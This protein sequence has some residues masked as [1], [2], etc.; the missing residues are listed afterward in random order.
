M[1]DDILIPEERAFKEKLLEM[2]RE[3]I[4]NITKA[5]DKLI[6]NRIIRMYEEGT[7]K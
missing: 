3:S 6:V 7:K 2:E 1:T 5:D 4:S